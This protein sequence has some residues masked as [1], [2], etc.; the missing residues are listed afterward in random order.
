MMAALAYFGFIITGVFLLLTEKNNLFIRFHAMQSVIF[1]A[2]LFLI[3]T[4]VSFMVRIPFFG[5][6][7]NMLVIPILTLSAFG[8]WAAAIYKAFQG[9]RYEL[10]FI[11]PIARQQLTKIG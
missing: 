8:F 9:E 1:S 10:P 6:F 11:G 4:G 7:I 5:T 2:C 3:F